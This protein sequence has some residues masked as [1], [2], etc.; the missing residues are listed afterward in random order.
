MVCL[1]A[2]SDSVWPLSETP[3]KL[4]KR[5]KD[6]EVQDA[7]F[8]FFCFSIAVPLFCT[9]CAS[10]SE[11]ALWLAGA[12]TSSA[13]R[14]IL[15][16]FTQTHVRLILCDQRLPKLEQDGCIH[17]RVWFWF[18]P[19]INLLLVEI[20][21]RRT[22]LAMPRPSRQIKIR[23]RRPALN[24]SSDYGQRIWT[25]AYIWPCVRMLK[26]KWAAGQYRP[27]SRLVNLVKDTVDRLDPPTTDDLWMW[28]GL[29]GR[30]RPQ[31]G[32]AAR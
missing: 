4:S 16:W 9:H 29:L 10:C 14:Y 2:V 5:P 28:V 24:K 19:E 11:P 15:T 32:R 18:W 20:I 27:E 12:A 3:H 22:R 26:G 25:H 7:D 6:L 8:F 21:G 17:F 23:Q 13:Q 30:S 31:G 1:A